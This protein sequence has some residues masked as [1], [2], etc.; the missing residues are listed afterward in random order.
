MGGGWKPALVNCVLQIL[1]TMLNLKLRSTLTDSG[2]VALL[3]HAKCMFNCSSG[4]GLQLAHQD[5]ILFS[6]TAA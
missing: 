1:E 2:G 5:L 3:L 6:V 4:S